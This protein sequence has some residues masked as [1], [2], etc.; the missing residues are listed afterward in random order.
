MTHD[1]KPLAIFDLDGTLADSAHRQHFLER[2]P[3]D[4]DGFFAAAPQDPPLAE[5]VQLC[6]SAAQECEVIYLTGRPERC[7]R[8]TA[9][10]LA[11]QGLPS[12]DIHMR[13]NNDRRPARTTKLETLK[14]L[15]QRREVRM[16][17][18]DDELVCIDAK[19]A[20]FSVVPVTWAAD[21][22]GAAMRDAQERQGRT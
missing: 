6:R 19:R 8:D 5:G 20:G 18:D 12:G 13:R 16:L 1:A 4:W 7:R 15:G 14:R 21:A 22:T 17:V 9:A 2:S 3:R 10:W 11:A